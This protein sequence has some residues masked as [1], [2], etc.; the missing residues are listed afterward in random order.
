[1]KERAFLDFYD[2]INKVPVSQGNAGTSQ[3]FTQRTS[4]YR[5]LGITPLMVKDRDVLEIGPGSGDNALHIASWQPKA[6][7]FI[8]GAKASVNSLETKIKQGLYGGNADIVYQDVSLSPVNGQ[9]DVVLFEGLLP[10]QEHPKAFLNNVLPTVKPGGVAVFTTVSAV[11]YLS[12][13][14]RRILLPLVSNLIKNQDELLPVLVKFFQPSFKSLAGMSRKHEDWILDNI[15]HDWT[16][17]GLFT[18]EDALTALPK[19]FSILG[20]SP[21]FLQDWRW[22][23]EV[24]KNSSTYMNSYHIWSGYLLDY[25]S[26]PE[27]S[28]SKNEAHLLEKLSQNARVLHDHFR[29]TSSLVYLDKFIECLINVSTLVSERIPEASKSIVDFIYG[30][31]QLKAGDITAD[32]SSFHQ[33]FGRGQ[34]YISVVRDFHDE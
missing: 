20:T 18:I 7:R 33:W 17:N 19:N 16:N 5:T 14:C 3:H 9:Y 4:L 10:G 24:D 25:R 21:N 26:Q 15:I 22:Y 13:I 11:S 23:K 31:E 29:K 1:M 2:E 28:F 8:D 34:Q 12:E 6:I 27:N 30:V 32:F